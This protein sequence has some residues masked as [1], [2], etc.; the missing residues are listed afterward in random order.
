[1]LLEKLEGVVARFE[2]V[3]RQIADPDV[4]SD[5][6]RYVQLNKEYKELEKVVKAYHEYK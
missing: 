6:K 3:S 1:M 4:I 2:E 5:M